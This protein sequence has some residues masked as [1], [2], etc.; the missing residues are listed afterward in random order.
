MYSHI[1]C[2]LVLLG[3]FVTEKLTKAKRREG[4]GLVNHHKA[5]FIQL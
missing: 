1:C 4:F 2:R 5:L 3:M